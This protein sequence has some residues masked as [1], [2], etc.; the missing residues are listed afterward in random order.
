[1]GEV[2]VYRKVGGGLSPSS[3]PISL[4]DFSLCISC[5]LQ[6]AVKNYSSKVNSL[7]FYFPSDNST[8]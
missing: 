2:V 5:W 7:A 8:L 4:A 1:M 3:N 6:C